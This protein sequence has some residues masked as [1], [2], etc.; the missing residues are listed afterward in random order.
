MKRNGCS[1]LFWFF[2]LAASSIVNGVD[3]KTNSGSYLKCQGSEA[4]MLVNF[5]RKHS[6]C[7]A[8]QLSRTV[9][10]ELQQTEGINHFEKPIE[11]SNDASRE[12]SVWLYRIAVPTRPSSSSTSESLICTSSFFS[13][14][15]ALHSENTGTP[16]LLWTRIR[17]KLQVLL[18]LRLFLLRSSRCNRNGVHCL[19][20]TV[21]HVVV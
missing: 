10:R 14:F 4:E 7:A 15:F 19:R 12:G 3:S 16:L 5:T 1:G 21:D 13:S 2:F 6:F 8:N 17:L 11:L 20:E 9:H 18:L